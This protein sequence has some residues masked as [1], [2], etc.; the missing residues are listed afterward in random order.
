MTF[1]EIFSGIGSQILGIILTM[2]VSGFF[3]RKIFIRQ[4]QKG[5]NNTIQNQ[6]GLSIYSHCKKQP[7]SQPVKIKINQTQKAGDGS[8]QTQSGVSYHD[9]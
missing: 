5:G 4:T 2:V 6:S 8:Q 9:E 1:N 7:E 3:L